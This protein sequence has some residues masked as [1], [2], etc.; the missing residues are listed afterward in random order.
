MKRILFLSLLLLGGS[1]MVSAQNIAVKSFKTLT[2]DLDARVNFPKKD[3]NGDLC[4][5]IKVVTSE[6]GFSWDGG[7][8]GIWAAEKK[9]GEYWLYIPQGSKRLT[10]KHEQLGT[11]SDYLYPESIAKATVYE[12]VLSTGKVVTVSDEGI[13]STSLTVSSK[14]EE[15]DLYINDLLVGKTPIQIKELPGKYTYRIEKVMYTN[16]GG[17]IEITGDEVNGK[18]LL[19]VELNPVFGGIKVSTAPEEGATVLIDDLEMGQKTPF[20]F[21]KIKSGTH[22]ITVKKE[23]FQPK[24]MELTVEVGIVSE[25][26]LEL[27]ANYGTINIETKPKANILIDG[28][29]VG[30]GKYIGRLMTG[31]HTFETQLEFY[32]PDK[33]DRMIELGDSVNLLLTPQPQ[34]GDIDIQSNPIETVVFLN[35]VRKGVTPLRI[36]KVLAGV[37]EIRLE[38]EGYNAMKKSISV[39]E[40]K[41]TEINETLSFKT[42]ETGSMVNEQ[43]SAGGSKNLVTKKIENINSRSRHNKV[44]FLQY[45]FSKYTNL[46]FRYGSAR[47]AGLYISGNKNSSSEDIEAKL[48]TAGL[49]FRFGRNVYLYTGAGYDWEKE[50][51]TGNSNGGAAF[52]GGLILRLGFLSASG[53]LVFHNN[54]Q[55]EMQQVAQFGIGFCFGK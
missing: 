16:Q 3:Q 28:Q 11:L 24:S 25:A 20:T 51:I 50:K 9:T 10:I 48:A 33:R 52:E 21:D 39:R 17:V 41:P 5:I 55:K 46:G 35:G 37:Y 15:A 19:N 30:N 31:L 34:L 36:K 13:R 38:K 54:L 23:L 43:N 40:G 44:R 47:G 4:A 14:P 53:G 26:N 49:I 27:S 29:E 7:Q 12:L 42:S 1:W 18:K 6:N 45:S 22:K 32:N 2:N 8:S